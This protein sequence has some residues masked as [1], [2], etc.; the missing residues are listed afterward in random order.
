MLTLYPW[1][2]IF[3]STGANIKIIDGTTHE[4][5]CI[6]VNDMTVPF[7]IDVSTFFL[8]KYIL[9]GLI[10]DEIRFEQIQPF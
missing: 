10:R 6:D 9:I 3:N 7:Y 8:P 2:E 4:E 5:C 1:C